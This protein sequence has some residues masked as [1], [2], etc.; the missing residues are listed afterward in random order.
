MYKKIITHLSGKIPL[1]CSD[2]ATIIS[3]PKSD[4]YNLDNQVLASWITFVSSTTLFFT[5]CIITFYFIVT[6]VSCV[7]Y[8]FQINIFCKFAYR[9][10]IRKAYIYFVLKK[11]KDVPFLLLKIISFVERVSKFFFFIFSSKLR[12]RFTTSFS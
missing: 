3:K 11:S 10:N 5:F 1:K 7:F 2:N 8:Y 9:I 4:I 12:H 6:N